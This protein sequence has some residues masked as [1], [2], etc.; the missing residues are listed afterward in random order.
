MSRLSLEQSQQIYK[1]AQLEFACD[2]S[3]TTLTRK[4]SSNGVVRF[5]RQCDRCGADK[6][7]VPKQ[8]LSEAERGSAPDFDR[9]RESAWMKAR[10]ERHGQLVEQA[11][12]VEKRD[13]DGWYEEYRK[14]PEW[15]AKVK[16][17]MRRAHGKCEG[18]A[19]AGAVDAHHITY[20]RVGGEMLFDLVAICRK[21]HE[22]VHAQ[23]PNQ[24]MLRTA[25]SDA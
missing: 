18:C 16:K 25:P 7:V 19:E 10:W 9:A 24:A 1:Q 17:V 15:R 11:D 20:D 13:W 23:R 6:G 22:Q 14:S 21:C 8:S 5:V 3:S 12:A 2:H 4:H